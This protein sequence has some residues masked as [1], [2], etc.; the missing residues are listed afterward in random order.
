M[1]ITAVAGLFAL[2]AIASANSS[3]PVSAEALDFLRQTKTDQ[4]QVTANR[5][6]EPAI[7][8]AS[9]KSS[10]MTAPAAPAPEVYEV[11]DG[12]TLS[13][14]AEAHSTTW[15]RLFNKNEQITHPDV[16]K[17]GDKITIPS[18]DEQLKERP[19]PEAPLQQPVATQPATSASIKTQTATL[20]G[21]SRGNSAGNTYTP[22][23]CTWYAKNMRSD[24]PNNLGNAD[25]WVARAASQGIPTGT[26]P[27]AGAIGQQGMHVV[28]V[29]QVNPDGTV[30]VSEMNF[31]GLYAISERTVS[32]SAFAYIY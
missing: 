12:E 17:P 1:R 14:I 25:T 10:E 8:L 6:F 27:R 24:L 5:V 26:I 19:L 32:A 4:T 20:V 18:P 28:Y 23:Y 9:T 29:K 21:T 3:T 15:V 13:A 11:K 30:L 7:L 16:I 2:V 31:Q 22:G